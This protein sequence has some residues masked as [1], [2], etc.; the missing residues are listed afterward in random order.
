MA[1]LISKTTPCDNCGWMGQEVLRVEDSGCVISLCVSDAE[2]LAGIDRNAQ[3]DV[4]LEESAA[5]DAF[6]A[7]QN[8]WAL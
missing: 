8:P 3:I 7:G 5:Q 4:L 2:C 6:E 1:S